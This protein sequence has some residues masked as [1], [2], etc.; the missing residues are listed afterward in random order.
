MTTAS[1]ADIAHLHSQLAMFSKRAETAFERAFDLPP[2]GAPGA[3]VP[4]PPEYYPRLL[5]L[6]RLL[7]DQRPAPASLH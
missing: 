6:G 3:R 5:D 7:G 1:T 4:G 2:G